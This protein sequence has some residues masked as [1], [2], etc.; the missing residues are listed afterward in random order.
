MALAACFLPVV[1]WAAGRL[2]HSHKD[3]PMA[4]WERLMADGQYP[5]PTSVPGWRRLASG[6][7]STIFTI[8][9]LTPSAS[10]SSRLQRRRWVC[11]PWPMCILCMNYLHEA[12]ALLC[13]RVRLPAPRIYTTPGPTQPCDVYLSSTL[14]Q[15]RRSTVVGPHGESVVDPI[16]TSFGMFIR[17]RHDPII[18]RVERRISLF[19]HL[20]ISHQEDIQVRTCVCVSDVA[21][22]TT[23]S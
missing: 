1:I 16:R 11:L 5:C 20:P 10:T 13:M 21:G 7:R 15:M 22:R 8:S 14:P 9:L 12:C 18:E 2:Q 4:V 3:N 23:P 6:R 17:R 19:T